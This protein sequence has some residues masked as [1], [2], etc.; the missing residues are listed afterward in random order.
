MEIRKNRDGSISYREKMYLLNGKTVTRTFARKTDAI[1]WKRQS[2]IEKIKSDFFGVSALKPNI[3]FSEIFDLWMSL[4]IIPAK[5]AKTTADYKSIGQNHLMRLFG[6]YKIRSIERGHFDQLIL[7][8]KSRSLM[9][10]TINKILAVFKQ[11]LFYAEVEGYVSKSPFRH[12]ANLKVSSSRTDFL[13]HQEILQLLRGTVDT[14]IHHL[15]VVALNTGMRLGELTGLCW[16][17]INFERNVIEV[18]RTLTRNELKDT[19]KTNLIRYIPMNP[20]VKVAI[21]YLLRNQRS[22][23][24]VFTDQDG[25]PFNPDHFSQRLFQKALINCGVRKVIFHTLRHTYAS[26]YMMAGGNLYDLQK[27]LG[28]TKMEM[29]MRY[30]HLSPQHLESVVNTVRFS[31]EGFKSGSPLAA[32]LKIVSEINS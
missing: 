4:K 7:D 5:S 17:R 1:N 10:K 18:S 13:S 27:I 29:T 9:N 15:L 11:I 8:L 32:P 23:K 2:E 19:T 31:T 14:D 26:Q 30:A 3:T 28:H 6:T 21:Q 20:E 22:A 12:A 16:D 24:F 25:R